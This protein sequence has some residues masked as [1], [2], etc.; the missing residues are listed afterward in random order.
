MAFESTSRLVGFP[1]QE[2]VERLQT[3]SSS[4]MQTIS[5]FSSKDPQP[6][7]SRALIQVFNYTLLLTSSVV[8]KYGLGLE[9]LDFGTK[10]LLLESMSA[11]AGN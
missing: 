10:T 6:Q 4:I 2:F 9:R 8:Q 3:L 7:V 5:H 1:P 11:R